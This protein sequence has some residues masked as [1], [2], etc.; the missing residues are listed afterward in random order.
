MIPL[1]THVVSR[2]T[3]NIPKRTVVPRGVYLEVG[4]IKEN[5]NDLRTN[6]R[7]DSCDET[8]RR[9]ACGSLRGSGTIVSVNDTTVRTNTRIPPYYG[10]STSPATQR[11]GASQKRTLSQSSLFSL[12]LLLSPLLFSFPPLPRTLPGPHHGPSPAP[13]RPLPDIKSAF[14]GSAAWRG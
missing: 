13:P 14:T 9:V 11:G 8:C 7:C 2:P 6:K 5:D 3:E 10:T 4:P 1:T 12:S